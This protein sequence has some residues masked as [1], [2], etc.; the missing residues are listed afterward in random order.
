[1]ANLAL[2]FFPEPRP[3]QPSK[4]SLP[5]IGQY[6]KRVHFVTF[7]LPSVSTGHR[8]NN[9]RSLISENL[10][11]A[12]LISAFYLIKYGANR[13]RSVFL[14]FMTFFTPSKSSRIIS[15]AL[16]HFA[17]YIAW[18]IMRLSFLPI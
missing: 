4:T 6:R 5:A 8:N 7:R 12:P 16:R 13:S 11:T 14:G 9:G 3:V 10:Q 1:M 2:A 15:N 18:I 17:R